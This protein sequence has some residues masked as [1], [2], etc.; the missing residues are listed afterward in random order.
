MRLFTL[1]FA[2]ALSFPV[3]AYQV[4]GDVTEVSDKK[5]VVMKGKEKFEIAK[6]ADTKSPADVKVGDKVTVEYSMTADSVTVKKK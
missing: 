4:T 5:I 1:L 3:L 2:T 6:S